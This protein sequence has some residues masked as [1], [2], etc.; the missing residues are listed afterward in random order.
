MAEEIA[1]GAD[2][3]LVGMLRRHLDEVA[4]HAVMLDP[5]LRDAAFAAIARLE[6][7]YDTARFITQAPD[8]IQR[9]M[10]ACGDETAVAREERRFGDDEAFQPIDQTRDVCDAF[11]ESRSRQTQLARIRLQWI[12][13]LEF[14]AQV[15]RAADAVTQVG[16]IARTAA[17]DGEP[18]Q[19]ARNVGCATKG[20]AQRTA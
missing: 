12:V 18:R 6:P 2:L 8:F 10:R 16:E 14:V 5:E 19:R 1:I 3:Q 15:A 4:Q 7:G 11:D 13:E 17:S 20:F 9:R